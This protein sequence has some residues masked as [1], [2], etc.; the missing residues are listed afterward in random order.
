VIADKLGAIITPDDRAAVCFKE[1]SFPQCALEDLGSM[2][3]LTRQ[4][5]V[6]VHNRPIID[7]NNTHQVDCFSPL[8]LQPGY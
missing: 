3:T 5:Y 8:L 4:S 6:V 2:F 1:L 7:I